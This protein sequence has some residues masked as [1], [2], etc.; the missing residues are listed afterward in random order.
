MPCTWNLPCSPEYIWEGRDNLAPD[1]LAPDNLAPDNLA[2][3]NL[4]PDNLAPGNLAPDNLAPDN[5]APDP[6]PIV[7]LSNADAQTCAPTGR[8]EDELLP[9][10]GLP[11]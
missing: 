6:A 1:N 4:A 2:P 11:P 7:S 5:L 8:G 10:T 3:D 9:E